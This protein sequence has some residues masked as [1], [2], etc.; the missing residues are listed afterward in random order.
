MLIEPLLEPLSSTYHTDQETVGEYIAQHRSTDM[1]YSCKQL[2]PTT[3]RL[4]TQRNVASDASRI[5]GGDAVRLDTTNERDL[6]TNHHRWSADTDFHRTRRHPDMPAIH[7]DVP[8]TIRTL[9][10]TSNNSGSESEHHNSRKRRSLEEIV[11]RTFRVR[12]RARSLCM[13]RAS[14]CQ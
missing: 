12:R 4:V 8:T 14:E 5:S 11:G 9:D 1:F 7:V 10:T 2:G 6:R 3:I 13:G